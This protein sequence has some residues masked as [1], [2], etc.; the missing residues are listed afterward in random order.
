MAIPFLGEIRMITFIVPPAGWA[1][2]EGQ[3][4][5]ITEHQTL[6]GLIGTIYG[7]DGRTTFA[8][9]DLRGRVAT[10]IGNGLTLGEAGGETAHTLTL[11]ELPEHAHSANA[12]G[13]F[14]TGTDPYNDLLSNSKADIYNGAGP[15]TSLNPGAVGSSEDSGRPHD[16]MM[17]SLVVN[18]MIA[19]TGLF[20]GRN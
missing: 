9:P 18:F 14:A 1:L 17:P 20:P 16:N 5:S 11:A 4:M 12:S 3:L 8:L 10:H 19:T 2:C 6:F 13:Q 15:L 7:G